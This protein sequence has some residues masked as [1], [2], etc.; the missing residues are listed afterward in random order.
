MNIQLPTPKRIRGRVSNFQ[1]AW[2]R[3]KD[4][5]PLTK[6][7][8]GAGL[9]RT[10]SWLR[11]GSPTAPLG[12]TAPF[13]SSGWAGRPSVVVRAGAGLRRAK[14]AS[15]AQAG[16]PRTIGGI[17]GERLL[18]EGASRAEGGGAKTCVS[19]KRSQFFRA[20]SHGVRLWHA[21]ASE[22]IYAVGSIGF[23]CP[24]WLCFWAF[25]RRQRAVS[26]VWRGGSTR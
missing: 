5:E 10:A 19:A 11:F 15:S 1:G 7:L 22:N 17:K 26:N 25:R 4:Q 13:A 24:N 9:P 2:E 12:P 21:I 8:F 3:Q 6:Q 18:R 20:C 14:A 23:V 16:D